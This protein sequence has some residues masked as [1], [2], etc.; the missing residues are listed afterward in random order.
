M[1][2]SYKTKVQLHHT[3]AAGVLFYSKLFELLFEAFDDLLER[4]GA[5]VAFILRE[6]D[7]LLP[8]VHAQADFLAPLFVD[9]I[10]VIFIHIEKIGDSSFT[11][12]YD[13]R[14]GDE[15]VGRAKTVHVA[16]FKTTNQK[17][18]LPEII[19]QGLQNIASA[20]H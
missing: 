5:S 20:A 12:S 6:S 16:M 15:C 14:R 10:V 1:A 18:A 7:F 11:L 3:D 19:R 13:V 17:R 2:F 8:F 9:D 4:I